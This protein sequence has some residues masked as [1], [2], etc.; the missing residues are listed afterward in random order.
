M[1]SAKCLQFCL[2]HNVLI[3]CKNGGGGG[4]GGGDGGGGGV[5]V[6]F[7]SGVLMDEY[8]EMSSWISVTKSH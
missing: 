8:A 7:V 3:K 1:S 4:G 5:V 6:W 2:H